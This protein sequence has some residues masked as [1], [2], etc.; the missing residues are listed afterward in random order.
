MLVVGRRSAGARCPP[1]SVSEAVA[2][3]F[4]GAAGRR[5]DLNRPD[6]VEAEVRA[7]SRCAAAVDGA[8]YGATVTVTPV[9]DDGAE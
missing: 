7:E 9:D 2:D 8:A 1:E 5:P 3:T 4:A 6:G